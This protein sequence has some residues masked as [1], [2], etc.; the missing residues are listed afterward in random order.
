MYF[1]RLRYEF[2]VFD[3][4]LLHVGIGVGKLYSTENCDWVRQGCLLKLNC[5]RW[6]FVEAVSVGS[7]YRYNHLLHVKRVQ[8]DGIWTKEYSMVLKPVAS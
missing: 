7:K 6:G 5:Y 4:G 1:Q 3:I 2:D 8:K